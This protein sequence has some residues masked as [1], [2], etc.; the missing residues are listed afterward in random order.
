MEMKMKAFKKGEMVTH[1]GDWDRKGTVY[2][3]QAVVYSCGKKEMILTDK[4]TGEE[5]GRF[6]KPVEATGNELG[7]R[8]VMSDDDAKSLGLDLAIEVIKKEVAHLHNCINRYGNAAG[9]AANDGYVKAIEKDLDAIHNP[10][11]D[12]YQALTN[13]VRD[14]AIEQLTAKKV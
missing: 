10:R 9:N 2:F 4:T 11:C 12:S 3:R 5:L 13:E 1:F 8:K 7:T 6:F 14:R